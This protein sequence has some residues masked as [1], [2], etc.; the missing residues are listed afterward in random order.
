METTNKFW[1]VTIDTN[2]EDCN[3]KCIMC[4]E[5]SPYSNFI[6]TLYKETG[7]KRRRMDFETVQDIFKQAAN[8]GVKEIIPSTMGEPLLYKQFDE[9]FD[10]ANQHDIKI[11]LTTNGTFPKKNVLAWAKL[12]VPNTTDVK[13]SWNGAT[14]ETSKEIM[15]G[16]DFEQAISN[17]KE[18]IA[19]RDSYFQEKGYFCRV[20]LQLTFMQ[21]NMHEL[22]DII[23]LAASLGIDRVKGHQLWDHFDEIKTL[24]M[25]A[26]PESIKQWNTY[27]TEAHI[28]ADVYKK[29]NG[30]KVLLENIIPINKNEIKEV[31]EEYEC[32]F[33]E[34]ELWISATGKISPC[35][36]P[37]NLRQSLGD[38]GNIKTTSIENILKS[39]HY[40]DLV[41]NYKTKNVCK[42]CVMRKPLT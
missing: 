7:V 14:A 11:N 18:F 32:P 16:L 41:N 27:V 12:I 13:I 15:K 35:C 30:E 21:Y 5:H 26:S 31:P 23:K 24:S 22:A 28:A 38:F 40:K 36:A 2:P 33:L 39:E 37:D 3:L 25:K 29:A 42:T 17:V 19:Y 20:T 10:L 4:E 8:L 9:I 1:R 6:D 34:Q